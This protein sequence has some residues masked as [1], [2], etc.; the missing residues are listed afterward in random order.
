MTPAFYEILYSSRLAPAQSTSVVPR[1]LATARANNARRQ[2]TGVLV[3]DGMRFCQHFEGPRIEVLKLIETIKADPRHTDV[4][5]MHHG[6][7]W[8][9]RYAHFSMGFAHSDDS[10]ELASIEAL[11][12]ELALARFTE[13]LPGFDI[14]P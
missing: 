14:A 13:L 1:I 8:K 4:E 3:F 12:G 5:V 9:Q 6:A 2:I 7:L 11:D 10:E